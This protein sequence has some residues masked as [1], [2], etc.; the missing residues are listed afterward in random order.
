MNRSMRRILAGALLMLAVAGCDQGPG[1]TSPK[2]SPKASVTTRAAT[3]ADPGWI[4]SLAGQAA[5]SGTVTLT[6]PAGWSSSDLLVAFVA[7]D[8]PDTAPSTTVT[9]ETT[10][11]LGGGLAWTRVAHVSARQDWATAGDKL[12]LY[13]ASATEIWVAKPAGSLPG[14]I[15]VSDSQPATRD[16]GFV[17]TVVAYSNGKLGG[18]MTLDGL[19][20]RPEVQ[21]LSVPA[22]SSVYAAT[23]AGRVNASFTPLPGYDL[24][25]QRR[26]GDDTGAVLASSSHC[27]PASL[28]AVGYSAPSPGDFW[29]MAIAVV[30]PAS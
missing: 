23:F 15:T 6:I 11:V 13:G 25:L 26:Y 18:I 3:A 17:V 10:S 20:T 4:G 29:E 16:D 5:Q 27:L 22:C 21:R 28:Q 9:A 24:M 12:E 8:G 2:V 7:L 30:E 19:R 1:S 14:T